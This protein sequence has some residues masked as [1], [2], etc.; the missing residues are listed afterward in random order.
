M[1]IGSLDDRY[2]L[3]L[4]VCG[5]IRYAGI[6]EFDII[7]NPLKQI[8]ESFPYAEIEVKRKRCA[9]YVHVFFLHIE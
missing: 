2:Y 1:C 8:G 6:K 7:I 9:T 4:Y 3:T 5:M